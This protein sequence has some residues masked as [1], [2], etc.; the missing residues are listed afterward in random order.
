[1]GGPSAIDDFSGAGYNKQAAGYKGYIAAEF[2]YPI[3]PKHKGGAM[4]YY[5][6]PLHDQLCMPAKDIYRD[7]VG[8][9]KYGNIFS[10]DVGPDYHGQIRA[11]DV[12]TLRKVG[13]YIRREARLTVTQSK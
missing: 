6:L 3:L 5:S 9:V 1:M 2:T 8:A 10:L 12:K 4:W 11:I 7:Y 13:K